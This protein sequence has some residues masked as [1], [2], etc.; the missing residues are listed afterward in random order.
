MAIRHRR[1]SLFYKTQRGADVGDC[2]MSLIYSCQFE[3]VEPFGYLTALQR[4]KTAVA[5]DPAGWL[6][7]SYQASLAAIVNAARADAEPRV[8]VPPPP[9]PSTAQGLASDPSLCEPVADTDAT[10]PTGGSSPAQTSPMPVSL[11]SVGTLQP[12]ADPL[13]V[14][15]AHGPQA[16]PVPATTASHPGQNPRRRIAGTRSRTPPGP[17]VSVSGSVSSQNPAANTG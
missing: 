6:P 16:P 5:L 17:A 12:T 14:V 10:V 7:W 13:P 9:K 3:G 2:L 4:H 8:E 1:N 15:S 11:P